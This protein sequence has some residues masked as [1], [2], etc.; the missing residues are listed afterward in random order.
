MSTPPDAPAF[1][2]T[3]GGGV[4]PLNPTLADHES[5]P[6]P[7]QAPN[8]IAQYPIATPPP[9]SAPTA[10]QADIHRVS[11][12]DATPPDLTSS[13]RTAPSLSLSGQLSMAEEQALL[14]AALEGD[15]EHDEFAALERRADAVLHDI[16]H[17]VHGR[18]T[19]AADRTLAVVLLRTGLTDEQTAAQIRALPLDST[20]KETL[21]NQLLAFAS[22]QHTSS[23]TP[24]QP[25]RHST[26]PPSA[27]PASTATCSPLAAGG[28]VHSRGHFGSRL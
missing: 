12:V 11:G 25:P 2:S 19:D 21:L 7:H 26:P 23:T 5:V 27:L 20:A 6:R 24:L 1:Q 8:I 14:D 17:D 9:D 10:Q 3:Q 4:P 28:R 13:T 22:A 16:M 18:P 15:A